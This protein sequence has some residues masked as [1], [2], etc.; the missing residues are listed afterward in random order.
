MGVT[1]SS[2]INHI[3]PW[4]GGFIPQILRPVIA[5]GGV[6]EQNNVFVAYYASIPGDNA[7]NVITDSITT[8]YSV[9]ARKPRAPIV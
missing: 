3:T 8:R 6:F 4:V 7:K 5:V 9:S 1:A 2:P